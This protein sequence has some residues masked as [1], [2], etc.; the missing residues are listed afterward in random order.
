MPVMKTYLTGANGVAE[1]LKK[2]RGILLVSRKTGK[3]AALAETAAACGVPVRHLDE[4]DLAARTGDERHRGFAL[5]VSAGKGRTEAA[6]LEDVLDGLGENPL[7][8]LL[9]GVT[10]PRNL[11]AVLRAADQFGVDAVVVPRRRSV[12]KD[13]DSVSRASAGAVEWVPLVEV[14]NMVRALETLKKRNF[15]IWGADMEGAAAPDVN[16]TGP[17]ALVMGREGEGIHRLVKEACDG[18]IRIPTAGRLDSL[19]VATAAGI[20]LYEARRQQGFE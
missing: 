6:S 1:A 5:E 7:L 19:N 18:L 12:S 8:M 11:G 20:L 13:A 2:G 3:A 10:D 14:T 17:T 4:K 15:W 9:D 16:L